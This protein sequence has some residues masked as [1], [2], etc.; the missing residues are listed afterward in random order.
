MDS[1]KLLIPPH[2]GHSR[3]ARITECGVPDRQHAVPQTEDITDNAL[4]RFAQQVRLTALGVDVCM[5]TEEGGE[6][7]DVVPTDE[8][9]WLWVAEETTNISCGEQ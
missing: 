9:F 5:G 7:T 6:C 2:H 8:H 1:I 4:V 3:H